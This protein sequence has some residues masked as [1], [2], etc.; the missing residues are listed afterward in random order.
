MPRRMY[1]EVKIFRMGVRAVVD[2][3][4]RKWAG[5]GH[6][7]AEQDVADGLKMTTSR[8]IRKVLKRR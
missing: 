2:G 5:G 8:I 3:G 1:G 7:F 6:A 4:E